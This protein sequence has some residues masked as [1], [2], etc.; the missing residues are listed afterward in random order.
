MD[1]PWDVIRIILLNL[2]LGF[3]DCCNFLQARFGSAGPSN[4]LEEKFL[5]SRPVQAFWREKLSVGHP[6]LYKLYLTEQTDL[7]SH[8]NIDSTY[9]LLKYRAVSKDHFLQVFEK[10]VQPASVHKFVEW[11]KASRTVFLSRLLN[12]QPDDIRF[13]RESDTS[14]P[15]VEHLLPQFQ[16]HIPRVAN[17]GKCIMLQILPPPNEVRLLREDEDDRGFSDNALSLART[18]MLS[19]LKLHKVLPVKDSD[20]DTAF[21]L[22]KLK[23]HVLI[24]TELWENLA[25]D[26]AAEGDCCL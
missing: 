12:C 4:E 10:I 22:R 19:D 5:H 1:L 16:V 9:D 14:P 24:M 21:T 3:W 2:K 7:K 25:V 18:F 17:V 6:Q 20:Q 15:T 11:T 8:C 26:I 23:L 13:P